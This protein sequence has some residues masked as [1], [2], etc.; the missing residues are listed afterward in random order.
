M[1]YISKIN[2]GATD[3]PLKDT[4]AREQVAQFAQVFRKAEVL[5]NK[6]VVLIGDSFAAGVGADS[7]HGWCYYFQQ[8]TG[9]VPFEGINSGGGFIRPGSSTNRTFIQSLN[10]VESNMTDDEKAN[11]VLVLCAG[12]Y[13]DYTVGTSADTTNEANEYL[14]VLNFID[15]AKRLFPNARIMVVPLYT[16]YMMYPQR[17]NIMRQVVRAAQLRGCITSIDFLDLNAGTG[18]KA[19]TDNVHCN[20]DG[21]R[22][23][24][25]ALLTKYQ[26][27]EILIES[28]VNREIV[29]NSDAVKVHN[30]VCTRKGRKVRLYAVLELLTDAT[31]STVLFNLTGASIPG[32]VNG[33]T[34]A[35]LMYVPC[36]YRSNRTAYSSK[37]SIQGLILR[38][39]GNGQLA[40]F[41][42]PSGDASPIATGD[43][44][45]I[46]TEYVSYFNNFAITTDN[47][48]YNDIQ[49]AHLD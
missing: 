27:G 37:R 48:I 13:N 20:D 3:I 42:D 44:I 1:A 11:T 10:H 36:Y 39:S 21:Y 38:S 31:T 9:C 24:A 2:V 8:L 23:I 6:N 43:Y 18:T 33:D 28:P 32:W 47:A 40:A 5:T 45:Y 46:D 14:A 4:E 7:G 41:Y 19:E 17:Y 34:L 22:L 25:G 26:G 15:Q 35:G 29:F 30:A 12:G 16:D 49:Y